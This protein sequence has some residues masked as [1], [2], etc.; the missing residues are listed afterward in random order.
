MISLS[1]STNLNEFML[2]ELQGKIEV[3]RPDQVESIFS[4]NLTDSSTPTI[5]IGNQRLIGRRVK[6][7]KPFGIFELVTN[8]NLNDGNSIK[9]SHFS[10]NKATTTTTAHSPSPSPSPPLPLPSFPLLNQS[11]TLKLSGLVR[12]KLLF[13]S[14][15]I[16]IIIDSCNK[17]LS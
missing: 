14:R 10:N 2:V 12:E 1:S 17:N 15:P 11:T 7:D 16:F 5:T 8:Y 4:L 3:L 9:E 6:L 13:D